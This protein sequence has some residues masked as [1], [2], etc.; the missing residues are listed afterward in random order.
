M[1][2]VTSSSAS[3]SITMNLSAGTG[4]LY[5]GSAVAD[6]CEWSGLSGV[7]DQTA[8]SSQTTSG[9]SSTGTTATTTQASELVIGCI[10]AYRSISQSNPTNGF[11]LLDGNIFAGSGSTLYP[12]SNAYLYN[13]VSVE[14]RQNSGTTLSASALWQGCIA[15]F[16]ASTIT[17]NPTIEAPL[18]SGDSDSRN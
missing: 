5:V 11:T 9:R 10:N 16:E 14:G 17:T 15:T 8:Y 3:T 6:I 18:P 1:G 2:S 7:V 13:I 4:G 12:M